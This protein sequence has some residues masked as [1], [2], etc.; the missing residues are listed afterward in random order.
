MEATERLHR[1]EPERTGPVRHA[2]TY[3]RDAPPGDV[4][5]GRAAQDAADAADAPSAAEGAVAHGVRLGY[6]VVEEQIL[7]GRVLAQRLGKATSKIGAAGAGEANVLIERFLQLYKDMGTLC[8]DALEGLARSPALR[9]GFARAAQAAQSQA[10]QDPA[11]SATGAEPAAGSGFS[12]EV[13][14]PRRTQVTLDLRLRPGRF[15]PRVHALHA[16]DP[17]APPLTGVS[18]EMDPARPEPT[19]RIEVPQDQPAGMYTGV[20]VDSASNEPRGFLSVRLL[21]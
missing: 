3:L 15:V 14:S 21:P 16:S 8:I 20:V 1:P 5:P 12:I 2:G 9:S 10:A 4:S 17:S 11:G 19:L 6:K 7:H 18:F 13:A